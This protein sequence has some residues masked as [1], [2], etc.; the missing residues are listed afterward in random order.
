MVCTTWAGVQASVEMIKASGAAR[1][2]AIDR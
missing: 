2:G 1:S